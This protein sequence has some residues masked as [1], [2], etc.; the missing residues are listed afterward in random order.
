MSVTNEECGDQTDPNNQ[1]YPY[2]CAIDKILH[3]S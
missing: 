2:G 3:H 1:G